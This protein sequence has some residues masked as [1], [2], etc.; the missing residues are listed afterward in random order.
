MDS[1][2]EGAVRMVQ[3]YNYPGEVIPVIY[4]L[5][6]SCNGDIVRAQRLL[7]EAGINRG[8]NGAAVGA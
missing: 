7:N 4:A 5:L 1:F 3:R 6:R 2:Y 8:T